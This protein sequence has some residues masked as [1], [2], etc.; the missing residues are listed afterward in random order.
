MTITLR[1]KIKQFASTVSLTGGYKVVILDEADSMTSAAQTALRRTIEDYSHITRFCL[2]CNYVYKIH[3][4]LLSRCLLFHY[5]PVHTDKIVQR[6]QVI[7]TETNTVMDEQALHH[8]AILCKGDMRQA[9]HLCYTLSFL[10]QKNTIT[11]DDVYRFTGNINPDDTSIIES[12]F[13]SV[14][15]ESFQNVYQRLWTLME[16]KGYHL[17]QILDVAQQ[18]LSN[19]K[20]FHLYP[21]LAILDTRLSLDFSEKIQLAALLAIFQD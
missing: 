7:M 17:Y 21:A 13:A 4:A 6:L 15:E 9:V 18:Y 20:L 5:T 3:P 8:L 16:Q 1:N 11:L 12:C 19:H 2:I 14:P 10:S